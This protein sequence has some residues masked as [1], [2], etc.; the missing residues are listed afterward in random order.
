MNDYKATVAVIG[1][2]GIGGVAA[3]SLCHGGCH[4]VVAC[5]RRPLDRLRLER[6]EGEVEVPIRTLTDPQDASPV[7]WVLL[8]TK[9]QDTASAAPWLER[10]C[11][12]AT[13][14]A[15]M[16]NGIDHAARVKPFIGEAI[17]VPTIVYYNG[18]RIAPDHVR[19]RHIGDNDMLAPDTEDGRA[20]AAL[21]ENVPISVGLSADFTTLAWRKLM[22][23]VVVNP[24]TALTRLRQGVLQHTDIRN[25]TRQIL[26]EAVAV[27]RAD[28]ADLKDDE[29]ERMAQFIGGFPED[30]GS[31]MYFDTLAGRP[32]E[33]RALT[34]A[35]VE[36]GSRHGIPTPVN[37]SLLALTNAVSDANG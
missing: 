10:L 7:D 5:G 22:I 36:I 1:L 33:S 37:T 20:F 9:A 19:I 3:A 29:A 2:G 16:Q 8:V 24:I 31:S 26:D 18:E 6:P 30:A 34:G 28:G 13:R 25:L 11:G 27:A 4:E 12:P 15:V 21:F 32:L 35:L 23:N 14:V 17:V